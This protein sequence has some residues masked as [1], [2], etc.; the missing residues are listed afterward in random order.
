MTA[1]KRSHAP[2]SDAAIA[3]AERDVAEVGLI[4]AARLRGIAPG[5]LV[6]VIARMPVLSATRLAC[7]ASLR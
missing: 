1:P 2:C 7:E 4:E 3:S 5:T 6:R